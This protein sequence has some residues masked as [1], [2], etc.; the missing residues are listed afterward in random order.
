MESDS[1]RGID[2]RRLLGGGGVTAAGMAAAGTQL[3]GAGPGREVGVG[4]PRLRRFIPTQVQLVSSDR[5]S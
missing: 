5:A 4:A 2:R 1:L 3:V